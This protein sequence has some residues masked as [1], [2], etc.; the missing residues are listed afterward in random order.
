MQPSLRNPLDSEGLPMIPDNISFTNAIVA[1]II[2][3][4]MKR[5][6]YSGKEGSSNKMQVAEQDWQWYCKQASNKSLIPKGI[7]ELQ[8]LVEQTNYLI[9]RRNSYHNYFGNLNNREVK[10]ILH[11]ELRNNAY[12]GRERTK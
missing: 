6:F 1:Y 4:I 2:L 5:E 8:N 10:N 3:K 9:P 12:Y 7:D 11:T